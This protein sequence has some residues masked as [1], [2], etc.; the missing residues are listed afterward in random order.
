MSDHTCSTGHTHLRPSDRLACDLIA[1]LDDL[2][3]ALEFAAVTCCVDA[4]EY[5]RGRAE[6]VAA[7]IKVLGEIKQRRG[8]E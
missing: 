8:V 2:R 3:M 7:T 5:Q 6:Q 1:A 4:T